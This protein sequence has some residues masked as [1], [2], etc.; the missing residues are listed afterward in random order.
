MDYLDGQPL[1]AVLRRAHARSGMPL[2]IQVRILAETLAGLHYAHTL[3]DFDGTKL[4]VV[5]RDVSPQN[6]F[7]TYDGQVKVVD[8]GIAKAAGAIGTT[9]SGVF[10]GKLAYVAPEQASGSP[11]TRAPMSSAWGSCSGRRSPAGA[12]RAAIASR[13]CWRA[14]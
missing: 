2:D 8:F 9:Q 14:G 4:H 5:H 13:R 6:V 7:V 3:T 10:K 12:S 1:H 11:S